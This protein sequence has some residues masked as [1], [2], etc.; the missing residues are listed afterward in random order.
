MSVGPKP[1]K[2]SAKPYLIEKQLPMLNQ[3]CLCICNKKTQNNVSF[4]DTMLILRKDLA[5]QFIR[6]TL[7][8]GLTPFQ[9]K[10]R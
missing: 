2:F 3:K 5:R 1:L 8:I 10:R 6:I 7:M 4:L 9:N